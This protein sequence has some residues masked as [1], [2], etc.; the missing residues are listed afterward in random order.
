MSIDQN[1]NFNHLKL[2]NNPEWSDVDSLRA[3]ARKHFMDITSI[4]PEFE[5]QEFQ[6]VYRLNQSFYERVDPNKAISRK[7]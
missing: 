3:K 1:R 4:Q 7:Y 2:T 5:S 6:K